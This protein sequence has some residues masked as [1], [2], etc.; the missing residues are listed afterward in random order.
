[1]R[2]LRLSPLAQRDITQILEHSE[3]NFG[4]AARRRYDVLLERVL[5]QLVDDPLRPG[6]QKCGDLGR[7]YLTFHLQ[8]GSKRDAGVRRPRHVIVFRIRPKT[9]DVSRVLH[10]RMDI[11]RHIR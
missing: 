8:F 9:V 1:M 2:L 6:V 5:K 10:D 11:A 3:A 4:A 7:G